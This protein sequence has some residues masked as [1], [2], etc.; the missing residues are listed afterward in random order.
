M[1][2]KG[3]PNES[4]NRQTTDLLFVGFVWP[5]FTTFLHTICVDYRQITK[6]NMFMSIIDTKPVFASRKEG[7]LSES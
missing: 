4:N 7:W 1:K 2:I 3:Y 6:M 5:T